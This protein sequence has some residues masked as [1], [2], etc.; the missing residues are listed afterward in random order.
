MDSSRSSSGLLPLGQ[1]IMD[2]GGMQMRSVEYR[3]TG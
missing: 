3:V 2:V 1:D